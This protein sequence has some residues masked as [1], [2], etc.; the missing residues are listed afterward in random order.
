[1]NYVLKQSVTE[2]RQ[3]CDRI[4]FSM[5]HRKQPKWTFDDS[6]QLATIH[7]PESC[8]LPYRILGRGNFAGIDSSDNTKRKAHRS[9]HA[10]TVDSR[11]FIHHH[12]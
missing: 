8:L 6:E 12:E 4:L 1:M 9:L 5:S 2:I 10:L 3:N 7:V 11:R